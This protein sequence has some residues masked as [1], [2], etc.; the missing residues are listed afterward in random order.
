MQWILRHSCKRNF[1][2]FIILYHKV[3]G[4][5]AA[6]PKSCLFHPN[7]AKSLQGVQKSSEAQEVGYWGGFWKAPAV[8]LALFFTQTRLNN[9]T[10][11]LSQVSMGVDG[12]SSENPRLFGV[13]SD[14]ILHQQAK[15]TA[16]N[17]A[18]ASPSSPWF[19]FKKTNSLALMV[20]FWRLHFF[21]SVNFQKVLMPGRRRR[22]RIMLF[23]SSGRNF[24][25]GRSENQEGQEE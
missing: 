16:K 22:A 19:H 24:K 3:L 15:T 21:Q 14:S 20:I 9:V 12:F 7:L 6:H 11:I 2:N 8:G 5:I 4:P 25:E 13:I 17:C 10:S 18:S 1:W 23:C